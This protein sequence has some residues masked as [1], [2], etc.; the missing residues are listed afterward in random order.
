LRG[1]KPSLRE[2]KQSKAPAVIA[3]EAKQSI[4]PRKERMDCFAPLAMTWSSRHVFTASPRDAPEPSTQPV[5]AG[6][7]PA[8]H[9]LW[10]L[11]D[12]RIKSGHD[13]VGWRAN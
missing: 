6:L 2:G 13:E 11:M 1:E 10:R 7:D 9:L 12:A 8:I 4:S 5:V 3:S